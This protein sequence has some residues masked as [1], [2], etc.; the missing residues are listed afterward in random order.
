MAIAA[1]DYKNVAWYIKLF[2][3]YAYLLYLSIKVIV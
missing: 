3:G 1:R 2:V